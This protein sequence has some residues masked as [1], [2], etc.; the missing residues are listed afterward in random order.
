[1]AVRLDRG[2]HVD[3]RGHLRLEELGHVWRIPAVRRLETANSTRD[4]ACGLS[5]RPPGYDGTSMLGML[6]TGGT[7]PHPSAGRID[8]TPLVAVIVALVAVRM[9]FGIRLRW[10]VVAVV[11]TAGT[12]L[13]LAIETWGVLVPTVVA[14]AAATILSSRFHRRAG[15]EDASSA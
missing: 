8:V 4:R 3:E 6:A 5:A 11:G 2:V 15:R 1:M 12:G 10:P 13:G 14:L 7:I 9:V